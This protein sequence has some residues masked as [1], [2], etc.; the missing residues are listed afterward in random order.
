[1]KSNQL[2]RKGMLIKMRFMLYVFAIIA[3]SGGV[4][5]AEFL[6]YKQQDQSIFIT[7]DEGELK[8]T[9]FHTEGFEIQYNS[10]QKQLPSYALAGALLATKI[11]IIEHSANIQISTDALTVVVNKSPIHLSFI[12]NGEIL[13]KEES[14][15]Y[16]TADEVGFNF[17]LTT[18]EKLVG[19][20][21]RVLGMDRRGHRMPLYNR[22]HYGYGTES[23][24]MYY[25][26]PAVMSDKK[27]AVVFDNSASGFIDIGHSDKQ[28]LS[29][30][31][32]GGRTAYLFVA[33]DSY[34]QLIDNFTQLTGRQPLP[35]RWALGNFA[36]RFG[37]QSEKETR[38]TVQKFIQQDFPLDAVVLD[39]YWFGPDVKGHMGNLDWNRETFPTPEKMI[40][41]FRQKG[42]NTIVI[43]EPFIL[44]TSK[45]WQSAVANNALATQSN[46]KP[47]V[48]DFF[49]G[50]TG[51]VDVFSDAGQKWFSQAY[52][53]LFAQGVAGWWGD[54]GEPEV[55]PSD[56][57][58]NE[59][60]MSV[61]A[62]EIHNAY[63]HK[64]A[65]LV[66]N[67]QQQISTDTRPMIMMRSGFIGSQRYGMI[68]WTGDV[69]RSWDGLSVQVELS[70]QMSL[71]GLAYTHSDL[72]GFAGGDKFDAEMYIR[73]LQYGVFQ[74]V[75]RPHA[76]QDIAPE[77]VFHDGYTQDIVREYIK[78]RYQLLPFNYSLVYENSLTGMPLMRPMMFED[79]TN[80]DFFDIADQYL[81]GDAFL[82][83]PV[84][85]AKA[86][87]V[88]LILP[89]GYW[90]D[91]WTDK[92]YQGNQ[93]VKLKTELKHL[94]VMVRAGAFIPMI[95]SIQSTSLY[96]SKLLD[97]HYYDHPSVNKSA[98]LMYE[99]DGKN[100]D[101]ITNQQFQTLEFKSKR[102]L[103][104]LEI[105]ITT[106][107][108]Y[109]GMPAERKIN[110]IVHNISQV[111]RAI[112]LEATFVDNRKNTKTQVT[113]FKWD[114]NSR[115]LNF[116]VPIV[117]NTQIKI[118]F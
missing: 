47:Y 111:P 48:Y 44:T 107:G 59:N 56:A 67:H 61:T 55:H 31:A 101:A 37:Y 79:E 36:S 95:K 53:Q 68:P 62:D 5:A 4:S 3:I 99:D 66:F 97:L 71:F 43:T 2:G 7:T 102:S 9:A 10:N 34:P 117:D 21:Q 45:K 27:Y 88:S 91:F 94:P 14:G 83:K 70:L 77:P 74:P 78:L 8:L 82:V 49:F 118:D 96:S 86:R 33:G 72:G 11:K 30:S 112:S 20:G 100:P 1:M 69:S 113:E 110:L 41:D 115:R 22:A 54:L 93:N 90:F 6:S 108:Q 39:L 116:L 75:Y 24:Q 18:N 57:L 35:P 40:E 89:K 16:Q 103:K 98:G 52:S 19:G 106:S 109:V 38:E 13:F 63:G 81:W 84:T 80:A 58:H 64:W 42:V 76:Q 46:G 87:K 105:S 51:L 73:W 60:G 29:F 104:D 26:L 12:K 17:K 28:V 114:N 50:N 25:G 23:N 92:F 85:Q 65:Q 32:M 15:F